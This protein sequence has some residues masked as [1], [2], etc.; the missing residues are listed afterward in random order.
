MMTKSPVERA[1]QIWS[2]VCRRKPENVSKKY[3]GEPFS[4]CRFS[5]ET[6]GLIGNM[7]PFVRFPTIGWV[8]LWTVS[9]VYENAVPKEE[10]VGRAWAFCAIIIT[11]A[12]IA[13]FVLHI[14]D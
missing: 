4:P 12:G 9:Y 5:S 3:V 8:G 1:V 14:Y 13:N 2:F 7:V 6:I 11:V 10:N